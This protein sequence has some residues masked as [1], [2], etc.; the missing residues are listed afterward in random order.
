RL[1][2][3]PQTPDIPL[4]P[5]HPHH[6]LQK[7]LKSRRRLRRPI[8]RLEHHP[9]PFTEKSGHHGNTALLPTQGPPQSMIEIFQAHLTPTTFSEILSHL[10][11]AVPAP[12]THSHT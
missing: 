7:T 2:N 4:R 10:A 11:I 12:L 1:R 8:T 9:P 3:R 5:L 6:D